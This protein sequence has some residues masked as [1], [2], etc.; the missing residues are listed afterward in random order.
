MIDN[1]IISYAQNRED[2]LIDAFFKDVSNGFYVDVGANHPVD[3]S[4][5]K[6]FY[7]RGWS[8]I[9]IEPN[10][11]LFKLLEHERPRDINIKAGVS[12]SG[13]K[14]I[15]RE[16]EGWHSGLSTFSKDM[17]KE[18]KGIKEYRD[19]E[20]NVVTLKDLFTDKKIKKINFLKV[21][22]EGYEYNVLAGNDWKRYRPELICIEANHTFKN[23]RGI[24]QNAGYKKVFF[25]GLNEYYL[26][27]ESLHRE[28]EFSYVKSII[29]TPII[30]SRVGVALESLEKR[31]DK[32]QKELGTYKSEV[33]RL[34]RELAELKKITPLTKQL[35]KSLDASI[36]RRIDRLNDRKNK[37]QSKSDLKLQDTEDPQYV[38][39]QI[40][41]YDLD[42]YYT[43]SKRR[44]RPIYVI[45]LHVYNFFYK[46]AFKTGRFMAKSVRRIRR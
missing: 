27:K 33:L 26:A 45:T 40:R 4:V 21:D 10:P 2:V 11:R 36:R 29:G 34:N 24:L 7:D 16:Y 25:D 42:T 32:Q 41:L 31:F 17:Q 30:D 8:G 3:D 15:F 19:V 44:N 12:D 37:P 35:I 6:Y 1:L 9:N 13:G 28:K 20:V 39:K 18:N 5:T 23:W 22:V 46:L 38:I 43:I 14:L